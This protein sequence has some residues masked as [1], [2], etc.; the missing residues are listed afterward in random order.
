MMIVKVLAGLALL[1]IVIFLHELGHL[2]A[3]KLVGIEVE[4]F[5]L[6]WGKKLVGF[7]WRGTEYRISVFPVGGFC[8]MKGERSY[9]KALDEDQNEIPREEGSF[10]AAKPWK[11]IVAL[12]AGPVANMVF[13]ILVLAT[14]WYVGFTDPVD[15]SRIILASEY[16][17]TT[18]TNPADEA[19]LQT[20]DVILQIGDTEV[21]SWQEVSEQFAFNARRPL[22]VTV[23]R[24]GAQYTLTVTP[25]LER[26]T[27]RG[28]V[29]IYAWVE[30]VVD[31]VEPGSLADRAGI[32]PGD[33]IVSVGGAEVR[34]TV[35]ISFALAGASFPLELAVS[36]DG[37]RVS[38]SV[39][40]PEATANPEEGFA[41]GV[42]F[43]KIQVS[44]PDLNPLQALGRG[45]SES[46]NIL[47]RSVGSLRVLFQGVRITSA[48]AGPLRIGFILGDVATRGFS[49]GIGIGLRWV[50]ETL[51]LFSVVLF[52]M[53]L[54]PIPVLDGG[55]IIL[56]GIEWVRGRG[57]RPKAVYRYQLIGSMVILGILV[58][59]V[60]GDI[61]FFAGR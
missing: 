57:P 5:S 22:P 46:F 15:P 58:V 40:A 51:A 45:V 11:R 44:S 2:I 56:A 43:Q 19:G 38:L 26:E 25:A 7:T 31:Y 29:G 18:G 13:A 41:L 50:A 8:K 53:N 61:L 30:P 12:L 47:V 34:H 27:G 32:R 39:P 1:G 48:V 20:G 6:G 23:S 21:R 14:V 9:V 37:Q 16:L 60:L 35:D 42:A 36:R 28:Y 49:Q 24:D 4:A 55:Q 10:F 33:R 3:A 54:L 17:P 52:F 59:A